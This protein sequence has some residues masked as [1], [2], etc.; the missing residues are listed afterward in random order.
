MFMCLYKFIFLN[1]QQTAYRETDRSWK[2]GYPCG[3]RFFMAFD[4]VLFRFRLIV[5]YF[6]VKYIA[7]FKT[8]FPS[9]FYG[10]IYLFAFRVCRH[11]Y[12]LSN[13]RLFWQ[14]IDLSPIKNLKLNN[15]YKLL[16]TPRIVNVK[17]LRWEGFL[18]RSTGFIKNTKRPSQNDT[19]TAAALRF[20]GEKC[21]NLKLVPTSVL[22]FVN[23]SFYLYIT[24]K[25][26]VL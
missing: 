14:R 3:S 1:N 22:I 25:F 18:R 24:Y 19:M 7:Y 15:L 20:I 23:K 5:K 11:F 16:K 10:H 26:L 6:T 21:P 9:L 12:R 17:S 13:D 4:F 2:Y 8:N